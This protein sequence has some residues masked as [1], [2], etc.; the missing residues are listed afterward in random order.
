MKRNT[1]QF[2]S[3]GGHADDMISRY[4]TNISMLSKKRLFKKFTY[5]YKDY[6]ADKNPELPHPSPETILKLK[7]YLKKQRK[8]DDRL[9]GFVL[10][11]IL[12][13]VFAFLYWLLFLYY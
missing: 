5:K 6:S 7:T 12:L 8:R 4:K 13:L 2:F 9:R 3:S 11:I 10:A 1:T